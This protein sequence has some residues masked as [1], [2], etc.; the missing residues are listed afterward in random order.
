MKKQYK[1]SLL[2]V[3]LL[4]SALEGMAQNIKV[5]GVVLE[6]DGA[7]EPLIQVS[8][9]PTDRKTGTKNMR[10]ATTTDMNGK[11]TLTAPANCD[12]VFTYIGYETVVHKLGDKPLENLKIF[13]HES[14]NMLGE[15][16]I[17]YE[18]R[19]KS[20]VTSAYQLIDPKDIADTPVSNIGELLQG[21]VAG[22]NIQMNNGTPGADAQITLRGISDISLV[23]TGSGNSVEDYTLSSATPLFVVDG[24]PQSDAGDYDSSGLLSGATVSPLS[25]VPFED[26]ESIEILKDAAATS[27]YGSAGAYGVILIQTKKG[28]SPKPRISYSGNF[29]VKTPPSLRDVVVGSAERRARMQQILQNDTSRYHGFNEIHDLIALSDSLNP[30]WN[31]NTDWQ[32]VF[33][34]TTYNQTHNLNFSGGD[35]GFNYKINGNYYTEQGIIKSTKFNRYGISMT[36]GYRPNNKFNLSVKAGVTFTDKSVGS[37]SAVSQTGV[38]SGSSASSLLPPPSM[39]SMTNEALSVFA[40][41]NQ[42]NGTSYNTSA[43]LEYKLPFGIRWNGT[44]GYTYNTS[45]EDTFTPAALNTSSSAI[46]RAKM[47]SGNSNSYNLYARTT[48]NKEFSLYWV[49]LGLTA[50]FEYSSEKKSSNSL[51]MIGLSSDYI[52]GPVGQT[53]SLADGTSKL[54]QSNNTFALIFNPSFGLGAKT[55]LGE[56]YVFTPTLRPEMNSAY[57]EKLKWVINPGLGFRWNFF[58]EPFMHKM[59]STFL[60]QGAFRVS[61]GRTVKYKATRYNIYGQYD[62]KDSY[63]YNGNSYT[64][65]NFDNLPNINLDPVTT[66]QWNAGFELNFWKRL[67]SATIDAYYKQVDNQLSDVEL[68]SHNAF[69]KIKSTDVSIVNYGL[70]GT[71]GLR[72]LRVQSNWDLNIMASL[73]WNKDV[74]AKLPNE[75]RQII[76]SKATSVNRLGA[77]ALGMYLYVNKGVYARDED[78]P[79]DPATGKRLR[80]GG[81]ETSESYFKAGDPIWVD[82][83]GDYVIDEKDKMIVGNSQPRITGGLSINLRYKNFSINTNSSFVLRRDIINKALAD[84]FAAYTDPLGI[85]KMDVLRKSA[86]LT[87]IESYDFWAPDHIHAGYPNPYD[88]IHAKTINPFRLDQTLF[89]EDGSYFKLN[90]V[91]IGYTLGKRVLSYLRVSSLQLRASMNNIFTISKYSG[92]NPESVNS[93]GYDTSGGYPNARSYTVGITLGL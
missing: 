6:K 52:L 43:N 3:L 36:M 80:V 74:I 32:N 44:F 85:A 47:Y 65:I 83:N 72:P 90:T 13:M 9:I 57:G 93:L 41:D 18:K 22:M 62:I 75:A 38:A 50:G 64:P 8:I 91:S 21:R 55:S 86:A 40:V 2:I 23:Q 67:L 79:V 28:N 4:V 48:A 78:V 49:R 63:T 61:W 45:T 24:I 73:A 39:Y 34:R 20:E 30:Y 58:L 11:F 88:Y 69:S 68:T 81:T 29:V 53:P 77:N 66:T 12:L 7:R 15:V 87:P 54:S 37:G 5:S 46:Q 59:R 33:Y 84:R 89:M 1:Y 16:I 27:L 92:I 56:K 26:I 76:N 60:T 31:N 10:Q 35:D 19:A 82:V 70:E 14:A 71:I 17:G 51:N 42:S 25:M